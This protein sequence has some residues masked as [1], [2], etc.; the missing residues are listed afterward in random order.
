L[1]FDTDNAWLRGEHVEFFRILLYLDG[2]FQD[3]GKI[4]PFVASAEFYK[5]FQAK[6]DKLEEISNFKSHFEEI[7]FCDFSDLHILLIPIERNGH[8]IL[9]FFDFK[10]LTM[11]PI[12]PYYTLEPIEGD[13]ELIQ[14]IGN[15]FSACFH[16]K[17][18]FIFEMPRILKYLPLQ[19][20]NFN[21]GVHI[22]SY[23]MA[24]MEEEVTLKQGIKLSP[25]NYRILLAGWLMTKS[26][27]TLREVTN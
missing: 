18:S 3:D 6:L 27:P 20:D 19:R 2:Y 4:K 17:K 21:C 15:A 7:T 16:F 8:W 23:I 12:N 9:Q 13:Q 1:K 26:K 5:H 25:D 24:F 14:E 10:N 22:I 11:W